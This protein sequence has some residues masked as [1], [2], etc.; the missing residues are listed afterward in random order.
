M[1]TGETCVIGC[2]EAMRSFHACQSDGTFGRGIARR[3]SS[4][5]DLPKESWSFGKLLEDEKEA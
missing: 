4:C 1:Y 3:D 5:Y 2:G